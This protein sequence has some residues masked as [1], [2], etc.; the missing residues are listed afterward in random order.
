MQSIK[1]ASTPPPVFKQAGNCVQIAIANV[2]RSD[3]LTAEDLK[4]AMVAILRTDNPDM[5]DIVVTDFLTWPT[6]HF[7]SLITHCLEERLKNAVCAH[8]GPA[9][10]VKCLSRWGLTLHDMLDDVTIPGIL[11]HSHGHC[12]S[13][14][15]TRGDWCTISASAATPS[16]LRAVMET[17][18]LAA[19]GCVLVMNHRTA[20]L[21]LNGVCDFI[22]T[23]S[24]TDVMNMCGDADNFDPLLRDMCLAI[25]IMS[26][27][28][29]TVD[30]EEF[31]AA[32]ISREHAVLCQSMIE[33]E[34]L[35]VPL[36]RSLRSAKFHIDHT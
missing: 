32:T 6:M 10:L 15:Q 17:V 19:H 22:R 12:M 3:L 36:F 16:S 5:G 30:T 24:E 21:V 2:A 29:L 11:Y 4:A 28:G 8:F 9:E 34:A 35:V 20:L 33:V 18:S 7:T 1:A 27:M 31:L 26:W 25:R 13:A 14:T 23:L